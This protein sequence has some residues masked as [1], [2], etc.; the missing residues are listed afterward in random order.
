MKFH[1]FDDQLIL[2]FTKK[3]TFIE[4]RNTILL[5]SHAHL[6]IKLPSFFFRRGKTI[7]TLTNPN[8]SKKP[9]LRLCNFYTLIPHSVYISWWRK[10]FRSRLRLV[11]KSYSEL[12]S[13]TRLR[14]AS[15]QTKTSLIHSKRTHLK[16]ENDQTLWKSLPIPWLNGKHAERQLTSVVLL[17]SSKTETATLKVHIENACLTTYALEFSICLFSQVCAPFNNARHSFA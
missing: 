5:L 4:L 17:E 11:E 8:T 6:T 16:N 7:E 12:Y 13:I 15:V 1:Y 14:R 9:A 10:N 3:K 2:N